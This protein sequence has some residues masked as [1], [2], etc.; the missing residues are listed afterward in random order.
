MKCSCDNYILCTAWVGRDSSGS[1]NF[2]HVPTD[3][4]LPIS[5]HAFQIT[6]KWYLNQK[7]AAGRQ[8]GYHKPP[9]Q[10]WAYFSQF[11]GAKRSLNALLNVQPQPWPSPNRRKH[12]ISPLPCQPWPKYVAKTH[13]TI[14]I[15]RWPMTPFL[16]TYL[17][18]ACELNH[19][20]ETRMLARATYL[21]P[22][23]ETT[24]INSS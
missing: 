4:L 20:G 17:S 15:S 5:T 19:L 6:T 9:R 16:C 12:N 14:I 1:A 7:T 3:I 11:I 10:S 18:T 2:L 8:R 22:R 13:G 23:N 21:G 24:T